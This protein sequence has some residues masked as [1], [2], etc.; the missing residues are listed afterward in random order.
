MSGRVVDRRRRR[1][2]VIVALLAM[3]LAVAIVFALADRPSVLH[4]ATLATAEADDIGPPAGFENE[5]LRLGERQDVR[6][7]ERSGVVGF[8]CSGDAGRTLVAL[9][10]EL[11]V[12][13]WSGIRSGGEGWESFLK[14]SGRYRWVFI[15]CVDV[16][17][18]TSVVVRYATEE[19]A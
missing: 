13:G 5:V 12:K 11:R 10:E 1:A 7:D 3:G 17:D 18:S 14:E 15:A 19:G 2:G 6:V 9:E 16:G 4:E 8:S